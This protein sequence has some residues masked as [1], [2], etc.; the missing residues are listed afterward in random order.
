MPSSYCVVNQGRER[1]C[2]QLSMS[3]LL[4]TLRVYVAIAPFSDGKRKFTGHTILFF[5]KNLP[6]KHHQ[7]Y[8]TW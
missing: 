5:E 7:K 1:H 4:V 3:S 6:V 2:H 8:I